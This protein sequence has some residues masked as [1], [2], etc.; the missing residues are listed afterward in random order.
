M[1]SISRN[2]RPMRREL[3]DIHKHKR[4]TCTR[5]GFFDQSMSTV[6]SPTKLA[7]MDP[8]FFRFSS[9]KNI[10]VSSCSD[11][12]FSVECLLF[13]SL[14]LILE[15]VNEEAGSDEEVR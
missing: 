9:D 3:S 11:E 7:M 12:A 2:C 6:A 1:H 5:L 15:L 8:I 14:P 10:S 13:E 4:S